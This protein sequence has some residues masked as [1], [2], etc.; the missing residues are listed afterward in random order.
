MGDNHDFIL[1]VDMPRRVAR[2]ID[3]SE[4]EGIEVRSIETLEADDRR[5]GIADLVTLV[6][7][8]DD[9]DGVTR[10]AL[11]LV[12]RLHD[13]APSNPRSQVANLSTS[14]GLIQ[15][16]LRGHQ[17]PE[18]VALLVQDAFEGR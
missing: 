15:L 17:S 10:L 16:E 11:N 9:V 13:A 12:L 18:Q 5:P 3:A 2:E 4:I 1:E 7:A 6:A 8:A 14:D